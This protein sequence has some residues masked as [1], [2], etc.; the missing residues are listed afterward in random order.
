MEIRKKLLINWI[1]IEGKPNISLFLGNIS[2]CGIFKVI[3]H[4][5]PDLFRNYHCYD[6]AKQC[7]QSPN[8]DLF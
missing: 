4:F 3:D 6:L 7:S 2:L 8:V 5:K 1:T